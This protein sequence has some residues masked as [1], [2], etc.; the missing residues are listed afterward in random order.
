[1]TQSRIMEI[2]RLRSIIQRLIREH[3]DQQALAILQ[4][5]IESELLKLPA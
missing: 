2:A 4:Q 1:M 3:G 5:A